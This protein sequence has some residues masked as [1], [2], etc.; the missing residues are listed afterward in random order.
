MPGVSYSL[1]QFQP[2]IQ[3][4]ARQRWVQYIKANR[5][6]ALA[7]GS[8]DDLEAFLFTTSRQSLEVVRNGLKKLVNRK[9]FYCGETVNQEGEVDHFIP[10]SSYPRDLMH[11]FVYA[12]AKCNRAK[13]DTLAA[14]RHL[15]RWLEYSDRESDGLMEIGQTA[16]IA[17]DWAT[18]IAVAKWSYRNAWGSGA[19]AWIERREFEMVNQKFLSAFSLG[20]QAEQST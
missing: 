8:D 17:G 2:L 7:L 10:F 6:N 9:C 5:L 13:S 19:R 4:L 1:R 3:Q 11:N 20:V 16:G 12:D 15:E 18:S 14:H